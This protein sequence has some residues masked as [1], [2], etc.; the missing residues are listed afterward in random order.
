MAVARAKGD[1]MIVPNP[2]IRTVPTIAFP[3]AVPMCPEC[4]SGRMKYEISC[5]DGSALKK[6]NPRIKMKKTPDANAAANESI[7]M[8]DPLIFF[9][10]I[11]ISHPEPRTD[12]PE[13]GDKA[14]LHYQQD[15]RNTV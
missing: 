15:R 4:D 12:H 6:M 7:N 9:N 2:A 11:L 1:A 5:K 13:H 14:D 10:F 3:I 8:R